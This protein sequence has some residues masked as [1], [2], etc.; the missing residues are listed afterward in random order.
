MMT[1]SR[2]LSES[3]RRKQ[4]KQQ[5]QPDRSHGFPRNFSLAEILR[6]FLHRR[7]RRRLRSEG[8]GPRRR[9]SRWAARR[10]S[11]SILVVELDNV[12]RDID[13]VRREQN[14]GLLPAD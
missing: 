5:K 1:H 7:R 10:S 6:R 14:R 11:R 2:P 12:A 3:D 8:G 4:Q 9:R 13:V